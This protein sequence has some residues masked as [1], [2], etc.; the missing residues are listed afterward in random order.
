[1]RHPSI[2]KPLAIL[3]AVC[4]FCA[5][6]PAAVPT[7]YLYTLTDAVILSLFAVGFNMLFGY[8]GQLSFG[9]AAYFGVGGYVTAIL[10]SHMSGM[11]ALVAVLI[12]TVGSALVGALVGIVCVRRSGAY[13]AMLTM[14]FGMLI[15]LVAWKWRSLTGGDDGFGN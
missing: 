13:F 15:F 4:V 9:H 11:P 7:S 10:L 3:L 8:G 12:G 6:A 14:A 2:L 1:M 5:F